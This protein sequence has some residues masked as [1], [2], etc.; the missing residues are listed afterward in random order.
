MKK[1]RK[2]KRVRRLT[3]EEL[4]PC[5]DYLHGD[6]PD[7]ELKAACKYEYA[8]ESDCM[9]KPAHLLKS[10]PTAGAGEIAFQIEVQSRDGD[11]GRRC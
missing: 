2:E 11:W 10:N 8:K 9:K 3:D 7:H 5:M 6:V 1:G 4:L